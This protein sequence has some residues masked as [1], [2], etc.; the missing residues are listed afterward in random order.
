MA[1]TRVTAQ[2][3]GDLQEMSSLPGNRH[4]ADLTAPII[5]GDYSVEIRAYDDAG[6]VGIANAYNNPD[7]LVEVTRWHTPK[8]NWTINDR[9]NY[10]DY[11]RIMNNLIYLHEEAVKLWKPFDIE[12]MGAEIWDNVTSWKVKYFNAWEKNL[13]KINS[14][15]LTKD[16]GFSQQFF[17]N[18]AFI[19]WNE[20]NRIEGAILS[21]REILDRQKLG[22]MKLSFRLGNF[23]GVRV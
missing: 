11:N 1:V 6:N 4:E 7:L 17:S 13:D 10:V 8:T 2:L 16:Y 21:M 19:Q 12:D 22:L 3:E 5:S 9:F 23:K 20:L 15:I 14:V 18:G